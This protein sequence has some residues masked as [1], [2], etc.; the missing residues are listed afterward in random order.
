MTKGRRIDRA[1]A[2]L[3]LVAEML[4]PHGGLLFDGYADDAPAAS[5]IPP[6]EQAD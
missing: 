6:G 1:D 3:A 4:A 2:L 5:R